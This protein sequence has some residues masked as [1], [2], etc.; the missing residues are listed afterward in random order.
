MKGPSLQKTAA[1][2][3]VLHVTVVLLA[4][5][6]TR[7]A[8]HMALPSPYI[9]DLIGPS[10]EPRESHGNDVNVSAPSDTT[11]SPAEKEQKKT[12][13][14]KVDEK[15]I[16]A[17]I[18]AMEAKKKIADLSRLKKRM[19]DIKGDNTKPVPKKSSPGKP[20]SAK[21]AGHS[22]AAYSTGQYEDKITSEIWQRW[23]YPE[24][25]DKNLET[26]INVKIRK[27]GSISIQDFEKKSGSRLFDGSALK[28]IAMA[29]PVTPPPYEMTI[30]IRFAP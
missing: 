25:A 10:S 11:A 8:T 13:E 19:L 14:E 2:S 5:I 3:T 20:S 24:T 26:I 22:K 15:R 27:D 9:V 30:G 12:R 7:H 18:A 16:D 23:S 17:A 21:S 29:S 4:V 28:A 6:V 1:L